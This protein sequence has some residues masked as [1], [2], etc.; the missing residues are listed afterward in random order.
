MGNMA[1][2]RTTEYAVRALVVLALEGGQGRIRQAASLAKASGT[3]GKFMEQVLRTLK[4]GGF[5]V[6]QRGAGGGYDLARPPEQIR[7]GEV[8][9]WMEGEEDRETGS[10]PLGEEWGRLC[11]DADEARRAVLEKES[12]R[13]LMEKVQARMAGKGR[14]SEY[15]I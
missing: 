15:Q 7:L 10:G 11:R 1:A 6:S 8:V 2:N 9:G 14:G 5:V 12:L 3:P 13:D 4:K